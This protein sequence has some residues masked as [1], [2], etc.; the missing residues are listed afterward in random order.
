VAN[1][2]K[3]VFSEKTVIPD[4]YTVHLAAQDL[5][6]LKPILTSLTDELVD[7]LQRFARRAEYGFNAPDVTVV[8]RARHV[9]AP[10]SIQVDSRFRSAESMHANPTST[11]MTPQ[12]TAGLS[13]IRLKIESDGQTAQTIVLRPGTTIIGRSAD[14]DIRVPADDRLASKH[15]CRI[16]VANG[17]VRL[18]DLNSAN[19]TLCN[20]TPITATVI[21]KHNDELLIGATRI[22][23]LVD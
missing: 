15:H 5:N 14:A 11:P 4:E 13:T 3:K 23:V 21:L 10:G 9:M 22:E 8:F 16:T 6:E 20:Q 7:E 19:G 1:R 12:G 17:Q 18:T 2:E